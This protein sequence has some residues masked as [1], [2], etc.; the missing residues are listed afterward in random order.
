MKKNNTVAQRATSVAR[1][2][3]ASVNTVST[4]SKRFEEK[5]LEG[6]AGPGSHAQLAA[7]KSTAGDHPRHPLKISRKLVFHPDWWAEGG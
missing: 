6:Q 2:V 1:A 3:A 7:G 5:G 4:W